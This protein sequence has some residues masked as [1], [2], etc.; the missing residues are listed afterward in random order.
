LSI[1]LVSRDFPDAL[2]EALSSFRSQSVPP[3]E[4]EI[5]DDSNDPESKD[6]RHGKRTKVHSLRDVN[7]FPFPEIR[8]VEYWDS[9][10]V[11]RQSKVTLTLG[12]VRLSAP[13]A[14]HKN[15]LRELREAHG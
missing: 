5:S 14:T 2:R 11:K 7:D 10:F 8:T 1:A 4:I 3:Y 13:L 9:G 12:D 15:W 6:V